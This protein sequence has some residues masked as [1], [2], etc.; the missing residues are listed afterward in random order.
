MNSYDG[1]VNN[2]DKPVYITK[3][4]DTDSRL[5]SNNS[6]KKVWGAK[7]SKSGELSGESY[8]MVLPKSAYN[9]SQLKDDYVA[10][11]TI[12]WYNAQISAGHRFWPTMRRQ[13]LLPSRMLSTSVRTIF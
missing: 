8:K 13:R 1:Y 6:D 7:A 3:L 2:T 9:G 12:A 10:S 4:S 5:G 11:D